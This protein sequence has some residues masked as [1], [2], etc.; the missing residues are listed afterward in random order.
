MPTYIH[1]INQTQQGIT[2]IKDVP[3]RI[4]ASTKAVE[5]AGGKQIGFY[6]VMGQYDFVGI[7]EFPSDEAALAFVLALGARGT[8]RTTTLKA[9]TEEEFAEIIKKLP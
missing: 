9:F 1:L 5:A 4:E 6:A 3:A 7:A 8:V 2:N